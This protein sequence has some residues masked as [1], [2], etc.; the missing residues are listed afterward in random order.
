MMNLVYQDV[1]QDILA[2]IIALDEFIDKEIVPL[3]N[4]GDNQRFFDHRREFSRTNYEADGTPREDWM[5]L[6]AEM[7]RRADAAGWL[8]HAL[9]A[10]AGGNAASNYEMSIIREHLAARGIGL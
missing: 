3:Q 7:R 6:L 4:S 9:P 2:K 8:R 1:S 5:E 10:E